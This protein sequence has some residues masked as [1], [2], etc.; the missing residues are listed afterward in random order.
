[1]HVMARSSPQIELGPV[2][3]SVALVL[4]DLEEADQPIVY[5][6]EPFHELTGY[7]TE[8]VIGWNCRFLQQPP[9]KY[10]EQAKAQ[11][12]SDKS[13]VGHMRHS[14]RDGRELQLK[15]T[16]YKKN[17]QTFTNFLSIIPIVMGD[18]HHHYA[19]GLLVELE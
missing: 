3:C 7:S 18:T 16:N 8:E 11:K 10:A 6:S 4:T 9:A 14:I 15:V 12:T 13:A 1:M 5:A 17:G 2:D 19:V